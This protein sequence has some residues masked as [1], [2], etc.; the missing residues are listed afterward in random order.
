[1]TLQQVDPID[2]VLQQSKIKLYHWSELSNIPKRKYLI[3]GLLDQAAMSVVF[4]ASNSGKTFV[5]IDIA[6]HIALGREWRNKKIREG[7]VVYIAAEGGLGI[8]E[9]LTAFRQHNNLDQ[10]ADIYVIPSNVC[11]SND[12]TAHIELLEQ[13]SDIQDIKLIVVDT[14]ARAMG[15]GDENSSS[16]MG[17]FIQNCDEIRHKTQAHVMIIHHSGKDGAKGARGHSSLKAALDTEI[18]VSQAS[19]II[20]VL[21]TKQRDGKTGDTLNFELKEYEVSKDEDGDPIISCALVET[22]ISNSK[23]KL[24]S[25]A[26]QSYQVLCDLFCDETE[27]RKHTPKKGMQEQNCIGIESFKDHFIKSGIVSSD[28]PDSFSKAFN[29]SKNMLKSLGYIGE[30]DGYIWLTDKADKV[31]Q[32]KM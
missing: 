12:E 24:T 27:V 10:Y 9:R 17:S 5:A 6:C 25:Q 2:A 21:V 32:T 8:E 19:G 28:K 4:G 13:L 18:Q 14:L 1:M 23:T 15:S 30:W 31:G 16:D 20:Q 22:D 29:R 7:A 3:K 26:F 11:L